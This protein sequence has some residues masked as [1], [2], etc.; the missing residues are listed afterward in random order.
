MSAVWNKLGEG[1][2]N[3]VEV[4]KEKT[5]IR[6]T[7][8]TDKLKREA[9]ADIEEAKADFRDLPP[10]LRRA[11]LETHQAEIEKINHEAEACIELSS[12]GRNVRLWREINGPHPFVKL[13]ADGKSWFAPFING[14]GV[15]E[16]E[17][18]EAII[19]IYK[20][21]GRVVLDGYVAGNF[22]KGFYLDKDQKKKEGIFLVDFDMA[23]IPKAKRKRRRSLA[24]EQF[25]DLIQPFYQEH[26]DTY[27]SVGMESAR[28]LLLLEENFGPSEIKSAYLTPKILSFIFVLD[29][30]DC[31]ITLPL[32]EHITTL[33]WEDNDTV[34]SRVRNIGWIFQL[35]SGEE[36]IYL[37]KAL[38]DPNTLDI[39]TN[40]RRKSI[41]IS[42]AL[43]Y[44]IYQNNRLFTDKQL[45]H[46][47]IIRFLEI[48][49]KFDLPLNS[50]ILAQLTEL[51][52]QTIS[53]EHL[54]VVITKLTEHH[55]YKI[56]PIHIKT[57]VEVLNEIGK[58]SQPLTKTTSPAPILETSAFGTSIAQLCDDKIRNPHID[59]IRLYTN[60]VEKNF[61]KIH[62]LQ[63]TCI[64]LIY[65]NLI[66]IITNALV[67]ELKGSSTGVKKAA[68]IRSH[69]TIDTFF[70]STD[71]VK[72][73]FLQF[74]S[75]YQE[76]EEPETWPF[77]ISFFS[78]PAKAPTTSTL[79]VKILLKDEATLK[80]IS[81]TD[82]RL[83][84]SDI[85]ALTELCKL[86]T[87]TAETLT[88][89]LA[90]ACQ[91]TQKTTTLGQ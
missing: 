87:R 7:P 78:A 2:Y 67:L 38:Q 28:A 24:S 17:A 52:Q 35:Y 72:Q 22:R 80:S 74:V 51:S 53:A 66:K 43:I 60:V 50:I 16:L 83:L 44:Y 13:S 88:S 39:L 26:W 62:P 18:A 48:F 47:K 25:H 65:F 5:I 19:D 42:P 8:K 69:L 10:R 79:L 68:K 45:D 56:K 71:E 36:L 20:K 6:K 64:N 32:I 82:S 77:T 57:C 4:D 1:S 9:K 27:F 59:T 41:P 63:Q 31:K 81:K 49:A 21:T 54:E 86:D 40:L 84:A 33:P 46:K 89:S 75:I 23:I 3:L 61:P 11:Q 90:L 70:K 29:E 37:Q 91:E 85:D 34:R 55:E 30:I 73:F 76:K 15:T 14:A 12:C 58:K